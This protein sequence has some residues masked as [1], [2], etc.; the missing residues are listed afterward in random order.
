M[1]ERRDIQYFLYLKHMIVMKTM[2]TISAT[3]ITLSTISVSSKSH[4]PSAPFRKYT[5]VSQMAAATINA[6]EIEAI[7]FL[8]GFDGIKKSRKPITIGKMMRKLTK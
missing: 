3:S 7:T 2:R 1:I 8:T 5:T 6:T 4:I